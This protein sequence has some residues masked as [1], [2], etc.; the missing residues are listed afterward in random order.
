M[1]KPGLS[2]EELEIINQPVDLNATLDD[3]TLKYKTEVELADTYLLDN[4][5]NYTNEDVDNVSSK[6]NIKQRK[7]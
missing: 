5:K 2:D 4:K 6:N 3:G 7:K 1:K